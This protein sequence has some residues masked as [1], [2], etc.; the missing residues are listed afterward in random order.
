MSRILIVEDEKS[1]R[2][3]LALILR[4]GSFRQLLKFSKTA[5]DY[6]DLSLTPVD[7]DEY[8]ELEMFAVTESAK[9]AVDKMRLK[10]EQREKRAAAG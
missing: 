6:T 5:K 1:M 3:L 4:Y 7:D 10:D 2:E 9:A 8:A